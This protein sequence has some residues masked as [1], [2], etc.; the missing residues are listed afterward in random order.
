ME[1]SSEEEDSWERRRQVKAPDDLFLDMKN[2]CVPQT[3]LPEPRVQ[4]SV[5]QL[6]CPVCKLL[7][8]NARLMDLHMEE[9]HNPLFEAS[10]QR[11]KCLVEG[12]DR[13]LST[14]HKRFMHLRDKHGFPPDFKFG[15]KPRS[16]QKQKKKQPHIGLVYSFLIPRPHIS[17]VIVN[18]V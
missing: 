3:S 4:D 10:Q 1:E 18:F 6:S 2:V 15:I 17:D 13:D 9:S 7:F 5:P 16:N 11:F 14:Q 12:C 8:L